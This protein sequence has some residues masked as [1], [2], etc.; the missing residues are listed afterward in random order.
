MRKP[1]PNLVGTI[2]VSKLLESEDAR[3]TALQ[4]NDFYRV[5]ALTDIP[6]VA[7]AIVEIPKGHR[8]KYEIDKKSGLVRLDRYLSS[9]THYPLDYGII[10]QTL[11]GDGDPLDVIV[12]VREPTF[13]GCLIEARIL[14]LFRM[15]EKGEEDEKI[16]ACPLRDP[17]FADVRELE[18][19]PQAFLQE[20]EHFFN[21]YKQLEGSTVATFGW[22]SREDG[23]RAIHE[24]ME[25]YRV[26]CKLLAEHKPLSKERRFD[27]PPEKPVKAAKA[28]GSSARKATDR[29]SPP[30]RGNGKA[31]SKA[32][33]S[34]RRSTSAPPKRRG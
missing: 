10:P 31:S 27:R 11:A 34:A 7:H 25:V 26:A 15:I 33:S 23:M 5:T 9:S 29:A 4:D 14:G 30:S 18:D 28:S 1:K 13:S 20:V 24:S 12:M 16:L 32:S 8:N 19:V 2:D 21:T 6:G 3:N 17:F 22:G